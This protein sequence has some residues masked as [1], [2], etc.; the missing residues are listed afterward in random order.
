[1]ANPITVEINNVKDAILKLE[2]VYTEEVGVKYAGIC[3]KLEIF[4]RTVDITIHTDR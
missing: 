4:Q 3:A 1:M 2:A